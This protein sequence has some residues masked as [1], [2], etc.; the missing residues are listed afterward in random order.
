MFPRCPLHASVLSLITVLNSLLMS[1]G[2]SGLSSV[3]P[4]ATVL[5]IDRVVENKVNDLCFAMESN[6]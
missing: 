6:Y 5:T 4:P 3:L 2:L 1:L